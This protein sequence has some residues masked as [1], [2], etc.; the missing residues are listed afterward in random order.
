MLDVPVRL[1]RIRIDLDP[2]L[3]GV[4][5]DTGLRGYRTRSA[6]CLPVFELALSISF[7][8]AQPRAPAVYN[9]PTEARPTNAMR[10][11]LVNLR[12][13]I[14]TIYLL[15]TTLRLLTLSPCLSVIALAFS[16]SGTPG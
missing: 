2:W 7:P 5:P 4:L 13:A 15:M 10:V 8:E 3:Q 16:R 11:V 14:S 6:I 1:G 12:L 9:N